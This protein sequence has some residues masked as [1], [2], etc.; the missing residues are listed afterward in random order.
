MDL[1]RALLFYLR[2]D[3]VCLMK[4]ILA[5][6]SKNRSELLTRM[7][8]NFEIAAPDYEEV[9]IPDQSPTQQVQ[10]FALGKA[11]SVYT[12]YKHE[13]NVLILGFDSMIDLEG[14]SLGKAHT[15]KDA[16]E[17]IQSFIGKSQ[18]VTTGIAL[19]GNWKGQY[20]EQVD[21]ESSDVKFRDDIT[22]C[23][24]K[25]YL[26]FGDWTGKCGAYSILGTGIFLLESIQGD[27]QNIIGVPV[28]KLG[29]LIRQVTGKSP[30]WIFEK[31]G[32]QTV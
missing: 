13:E 32:R 23:Q 3:F 29:N 15:K 25:K 4:I 5:S 21:F 30:L 14:K 6:S 27:F 9:I 1:L 11:Q 10:D 17:M 20:F 26:E 18:K 24:I 2:L 28:I 31:A 7:G 19:I 12:K 22:N 8:I 16:F